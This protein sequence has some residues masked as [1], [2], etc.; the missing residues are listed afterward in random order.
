MD[1]TKAAN[2]LKHQAQTIRHLVQGLTQDQA[3]WQPDPDSWSI[4]QVVRHL[5]YEELWDF[6]F[7]LEHILLHPEEPWEEH[8]PA[9][10]AYTEMT[11]PAILAEFE[12]ERAAAIDWLLQLPSHCAWEQPV[13]MPWG[14]PLSGGDMLASWLAHDLLHIRQLVTLRYALTAAANRPHS[15]KYAGDW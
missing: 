15:V 7:H 14:A 12:A 1:R 2:Q 3:H 9:K 8:G 11:L 6:P 4:L 13:A 10:K 5:V